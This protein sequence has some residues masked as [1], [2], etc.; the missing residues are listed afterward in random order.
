LIRKYKGTLRVIYIVRLKKR[1]KTLGSPLCLDTVNASLVNYTLLHLQ[2]AYKMA[3]LSLDD[4][5]KAA[6]KLIEQSPPGE[7]K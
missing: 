4:K 1:S 2:S 5:C 6:A 7:V 3:E